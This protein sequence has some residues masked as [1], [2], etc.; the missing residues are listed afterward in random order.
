[1]QLPDA[2]W[3]NQPNYSAP[4]S[5]GSVTFADA[6]NGWLYGPGLWA[7]H[8]GGASWHKVDTHGAQVH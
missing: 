8:N 3:E 4:D 7:T 1:M 2:P 6:R 5:V